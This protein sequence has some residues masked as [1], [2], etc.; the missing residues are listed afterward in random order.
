MLRCLIS[1]L[2]VD[3]FAVCGYLRAGTTKIDADSR[4]IASAASAPQ[5]QRDGG[6][7]RHRQRTDHSGR[8]AN[9]EPMDL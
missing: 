1:L 8:Q 5:D 4:I 9:T 7:D 3:A 6:D 2:V